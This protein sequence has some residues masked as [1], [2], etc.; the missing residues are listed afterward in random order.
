MDTI[1][2]KNVQ[3]LDQESK[4]KIDEMTQKIKELENQAED[5]GRQ[6]IDLE[7]EKRIQDMQ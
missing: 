4:Q 1:R 7:T 3:S 2:D 6:A 5:E